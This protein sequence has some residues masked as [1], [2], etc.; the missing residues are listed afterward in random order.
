VV[1]R[2]LTVLKK[3]I[4]PVSGRK[5]AI[6]IARSAIELLVAEKEEGSLSCPIASLSL[7]F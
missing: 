2:W 6:T 3:N 1:N 4:D 7:R 5:M